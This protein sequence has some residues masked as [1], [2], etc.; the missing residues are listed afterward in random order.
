MATFSFGA[1]SENPDDGRDEKDEK[2]EALERKFSSM[3][4]ENKELKRAKKE[5]EM[6]LQ[7]TEALLVNVSIEPNTAIKAKPKFPLWTH[8]KIIIALLKNPLK[9]KIPHSASVPIRKVI[10]V[11]GILLSSPRIFQ[12]FCS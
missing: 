12:I 7:Q 8:A 1:P 10:A 6:K 9:G 3:K 4:L 11:I 2:Y 5:V